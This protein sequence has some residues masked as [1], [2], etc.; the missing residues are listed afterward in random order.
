ME[1]EKFRRDS[2]SL[3]SP[4][5]WSVFIGDMCFYDVLK[6]QC[7]FIQD[8]SRTQFNLKLILLAIILFAYGFTYRLIIIY[9]FSYLW[10]VLCLLT[11]F[12]C[13]YIFIA[14]LNYGA[15]LSFL[16]CLFCFYSIIMCIFISF[17]FSSFRFYLFFSFH[18]YFFLK[19]GSI[20]FFLNFFRFPFFCL[21]LSFF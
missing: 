20:L 4:L 3:R 13:S 7:H 16:I 19:W 14:L 11:P 18:Y 8:S 21:F 12:V 15:F 5:S 9:C 1:T 6:V 10:I 2:I 17:F